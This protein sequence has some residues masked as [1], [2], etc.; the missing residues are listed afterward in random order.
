M[1]YENCGSPEQIEHLDSE[2]ESS[3]AN[4]NKLL[5]QALNRPRTESSVNEK[6]TEG[7]TTVRSTF[8][9]ENK[10]KLF[11]AQTDEASS[12]K[13]ASIPF[14]GSGEIGKGFSHFLDE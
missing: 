11:P 8:Y 1:S 6:K 3:A 10:I 13:I 7:A 5:D 14:I 2:F 4:L 12:S 9:S